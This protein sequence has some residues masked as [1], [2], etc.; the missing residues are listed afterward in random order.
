MGF[1]VREVLVLRGHVVVS[2][3]GMIGLVISHG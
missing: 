1:W 2:P 3:L